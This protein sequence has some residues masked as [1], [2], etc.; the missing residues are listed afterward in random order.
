M[1]TIELV[2]LI[3]AG[4]L[5]LGWVLGSFIRTGNPSG[6]CSCC[7]EAGHYHHVDEGTCVVCGH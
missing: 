6:E 7:A 1:T 3:F 2:V 4:I 5:V